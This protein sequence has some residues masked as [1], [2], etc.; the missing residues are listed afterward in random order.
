MQ[1]RL[2]IAAALARVGRLVG[3][4]ALALVLAGCSVS[5]R[6]AQAPATECEMAL[7]TGTLVEE[8]RSGLGVDDGSELLTAVVWPFGYTAR[9]DVGRV[10][11][12]DETGRVVAH[13][14]DEIMLGGGFGTDAFHACGQVSIVAP[15]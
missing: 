1:V 8:P 13:V 14:G 6:T 11:L 12:V 4:A 9:D 15:G 5:L 3:A 10:A 7:L 2:V